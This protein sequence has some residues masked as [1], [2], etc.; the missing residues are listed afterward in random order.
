[1]MSAELFLV[2]VYVVLFMH[3]FVII[4]N[5]IKTIK[6][7]KVSIGLL[8]SILI[9]FMIIVVVGIVTDNMIAIIN[10]G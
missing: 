2:T 3:I 8:M 7:K 9:L 4:I 1:M 10:M 6:E 5:L